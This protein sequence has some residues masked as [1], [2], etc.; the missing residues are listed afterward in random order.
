M[1]W[2]NV[3]GDIAE[4]REGGLGGVACEGEDEGSREEVGGDGRMGVEVC[5]AHKASSHP[6][7]FTPSHKHWANLYIVSGGMCRCGGML[8]WKRILYCIIW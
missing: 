4:G 1:R 8:P 2:S 5:R 3:R 7:I 6:H